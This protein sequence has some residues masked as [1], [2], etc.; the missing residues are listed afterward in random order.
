[1]HMQSF[2]S[3][4][5]K[6]VE[7]ELVR[8]EYP[9]DLPPLPP[10][11]AG[12]YYDPEFYA[13]EMEHLF[14]KNW[15]HAGHVSEIVEIGSFKLFEQLGLS[16]IVCRTSDNEIRAFRNVCRHRGAALVT[17][18]SGKTKRFVCPYHAWGYDLSG[19]LRSVPEAQNFA[20]LDK[21]K[22]SMMSVRCETWRGFIFIN[23]DD[24]A[25]PLTDFMAPLDANVGPFP[26]DTMSVKVVIKMEID[27]NWKSALDNFIEI[28]HVHT[29]HTRTIAPFIDPKSFSVFRLP[30]GH[31]RMNSK[32]RNAA[33][34][35][36][37]GEQSGRLKVDPVFD[38]YTVAFPRF[39][40]GFFSLDPAGCTWMNFWPIAP[41]KMMVEHYSIGPDMGS[42]TEDKAYWSA[43]E[44]MNRKILAED[45]ELFPGMRRAMESG[46]LTEILLGSQEQAIYWYNEE[47]DRRIGIDKIPEKFR[48]QRVLGASAQ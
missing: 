21:S 11:P 23:E 27:C 26:I 19:D 3:R 2:E 37:D 1:M 8:T 15:V 10:V 18:P 12:R 13:L 42:P 7:A 25:Q 44:Q 5:A 17:Q 34:I 48:I 4:V 45:I 43:F 20:C 32:K 30:N 22:L 40:N 28:Y 35:F 24:E 16:I 38:S 39:P 41:G 47:I 14:R 46:E 9:A 31:A 36:A 29:V 6:A 33:T